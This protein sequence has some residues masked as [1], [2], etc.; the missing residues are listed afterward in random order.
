ML[1]LH[2]ISDANCKLPILSA[3][4]TLWS[5][6]VIAWMC[7]THAVFKQSR[8][9]SKA[10][11]YNRNY[12]FIYFYD[13]MLARASTVQFSFFHRERPIQYNGCKQWRIQGGQS[14]HDPHSVFSHPFQR[15]NKHE[16]LRNILNFPPPSRM[17][18][19]AMRCKVRM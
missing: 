4:L 14:G 13:W 3:A 18:G 12:Y 17:F 2:K 10:V 15:R 6:F 11:A 16:T 7:S 19:S 9:F 5:S 1:H 8:S